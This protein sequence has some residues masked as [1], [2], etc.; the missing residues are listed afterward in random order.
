MAIR[1]MSS[2]TV[3][4]VAPSVNFI[5]IPDGPMI[6]SGRTCMNYSIQ[7]VLKSVSYDLSDTY[8][9]DLWTLTFSPLKSVANLT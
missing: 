1:M 6:D 7:I 8:D 3:G 5:G 9:V 2:Q 4:K